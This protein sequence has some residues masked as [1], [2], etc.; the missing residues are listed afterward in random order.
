MRTVLVIGVG[1]G[2]PDHVT[3]QAVKALQRV[4]VFFVLDKGEVKQELVD[5]REE[6]LRR[7]LGDRPVR[8]VRGRDPERDRKAG[9]YAEAVHD[10]R[11]R[12]ADVC[13]DMIERE[14]GPDQTGAFLVWGDPS[15]YDSTLA[16]LEDVLARPGFAFEIEVI[17]GITSVSAL[18]ARHRVGVN[19]VGRPV[20]ITTGR[21]LAEHW[22]DGVDDVVVM[23]DAHTTFA[24]LDP[25]VE[26][27]W[28]AY[29]GMPDEILIHGTVA[30]AAPRIAEARAKARAEK[31]WIM[32]TYLLRRPADS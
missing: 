11:R 9:A 15:L 17:P 18:A 30:E 32:D 27:F 29:L 8:L 16:I 13:A 31:G 25:D 21:R 2:D 19:R 3:V 22:P 5:V 10:W 7:H 24:D 6:I 12:R 20:Q 26:I 23:L 1:A 28:G 4:D 14:L